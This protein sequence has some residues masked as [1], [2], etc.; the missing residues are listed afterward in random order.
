MAENRN[1]IREKTIL[2]EKLESIKKEMVHVQLYESAAQLQDII[3]DIKY[4]KMR[5]YE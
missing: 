4:N 5:Y 3:K 2:V 1:N